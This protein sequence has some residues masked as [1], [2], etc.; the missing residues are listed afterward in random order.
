MWKILL[1]NDRILNLVNAD[2]LNP[3]SDSELRPSDEPPLHTSRF[4]IPIPPTKIRF[5]DDQDD[6][7]GL[8]KYVIYEDLR[9]RR[10]IINSAPTTGSPLKS[11][12]L[13]CFG[14]YHPSSCAHICGPVPGP[15]FQDRDRGVIS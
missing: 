8:L 1:F 11:N 5:R 4:G 2:T 3:D 9:S 6:A 12:D 7:Q 13:G 15:L 10:H 14:S